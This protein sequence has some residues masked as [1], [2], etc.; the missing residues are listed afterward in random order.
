MKTITLLT[1]LMI[2]RIQSIL[3]TKVK[4]QTQLTNHVKEDSGA[5]SEDHAKKVKP[6][7]QSLRGG[8]QKKQG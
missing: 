4:V 2:S 7:A 8:L 5:C 6:Q 3:S 1:A